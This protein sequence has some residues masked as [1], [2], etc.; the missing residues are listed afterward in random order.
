MAVGPVSEI[1]ACQRLCARPN[2]NWA[3]NDGGAGQPGTAIPETRIE[4]AQTRAPS[5]LSATPGDPAPLRNAQGCFFALFRYFAPR[6]TG[7]RSLPRRSCSWLAHLRR[8]LNTFRDGA[9]EAEHAID[10]SLGSKVHKLCRRIG[11]FD[12]WG[13]DFLLT[14]FARRRALEAPRRG[15]LQMPGAWGPGGGDCLRSR[16]CGKLLGIV[17]SLVAVIAFVQPLAAAGP[18]VREGLSWKRQ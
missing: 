1:R 7:S 6:T 16:L 15:A 8:T 17:A 12:L 13:L 4:S 11:C 14:L 5:A 9:R 10:G 3:C 2:R 18:V